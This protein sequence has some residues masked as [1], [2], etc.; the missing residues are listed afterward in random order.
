M[1][2]VLGTAATSGCTS[3]RACRAANRL[4]LSATVRSTGRADGDRAN[5]RIAFRSSKIIAFHF[6]R[7]AG[8]RFD[9]RIPAGSDNS[10]AV[11]K[12]QRELCVSM[13]GRLWDSSCRA[14][15]SPATRHVP[16]RRLEGNDAMN[17]VNNEG[18]SDRL[19]GLICPF[20]YCP[21]RGRDRK[22]DYSSVRLCVSRPEMSS[23]D[24]LTKLF[25]HHARPLDH[26]T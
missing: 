7:Y 9:G 16:R 15:H 23:S 3:T 2:N 6:Q 14:R 19:S 18:R 24:W 11:P 5:T 21:R 20:R 1:R 17:V 22:R 4:S 8:S 25:S 26:R 12:A 10:E 13:P